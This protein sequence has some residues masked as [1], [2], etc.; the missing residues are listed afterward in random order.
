M[1]LDIPRLKRDIKDRANPLDV[2]R[3]LHPAPEISRSGNVRCPSPHHEDTDPSM[4]LD[5]STGRFHCYVCHNSG[6]GGGDVLDLWAFAHGREA[7]GESFKRTVRELADFCGL[8]LDAYRLDGDDSSTAGADRSLPS[9]GLE[10]MAPEGRDWS[11]VRDAMEMERKIELGHQTIRTIWRNIDG[12][13]DRGRAYLGDQREIDPDFADARGV[14]SLTRDR[15]HDIINHFDETALRA[16]GL[17]TYLTRPDWD[18]P[19]DRHCL[20]HGLVFAYM[21]PE[22]E[23]LQLDTLRFRKSS[24]GHNVR[25]LASTFDVWPGLP[26]GTAPHQPTLPYLGWDAPD[27]ADVY[28]RPIFIVEGEID[29]LSI[30]QTSRPVMGTIS[31]S[32][33]RDPWCDLWGDHDVIVLADGDQPGEQLAHTVKRRARKVRG[34]DWFRRHFDA[35][36]LTLDGDPADT[37]DWNRQID[38]DETLYT[39]EREIA[40]V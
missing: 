12:I 35:R 34:D 21:R 39:L 8:T 5:E 17:A 36:Q 4:S 31:A 27:V 28:S 14:R 15:L 20:E 1:T 24:P 19:P 3:H 25:S 18:T 30:A 32:T 2:Y 22:E 9:A 40:Y 16:A 33:W 29:A 23:G 26:K 13:D 38:L 37:N 7:T 11:D 6:D 10:R